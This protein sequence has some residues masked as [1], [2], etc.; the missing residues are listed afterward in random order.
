MEVQHARL[1]QVSGRDNMPLALGAAQRILNQSGA[2]QA[3]GAG[4][5]DNEQQQQSGASQAFGAVAWD[6]EQQQQP[7]WHSEMTIASSEVVQQSQRDA[8]AAQ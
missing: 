5:W 8:T 1:V 3:F 2:S 6:N 7:D 4:G